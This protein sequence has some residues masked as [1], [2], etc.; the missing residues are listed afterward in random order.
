ME[1]TP[2]SPDTE[3]PTPIESPIET[4]PQQ[5]ESVPHEA[6]ITEGLFVAE[7][8][9]RQPQILYEQVGK[10]QDNSLEPFEKMHERKVEVRDEP[11]TS[12]VVSIGSVVADMPNPQTAY[13]GTATL[14]GT[15]PGNDAMQQNAVPGSNSTSIFSSPVY[16]Q[17]MM[18][19]FLAALVA[20]ALFLF[21]MLLTRLL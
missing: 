18:M 5:P 17:A 16:R 15:N 21:V 12:P 6:Q 10:T 7:A 9:S 1:T 11:T 3:L 19:G 4:L 20:V 8:L 14:P 13:S 2:Y